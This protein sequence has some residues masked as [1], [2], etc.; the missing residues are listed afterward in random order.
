VVEVIYFLL[1]VIYF[2]GENE[3]CS[4]AINASSPHYDATFRVINAPRFPEKTTALSSPATIR[5]FWFQS[6]INSALLQLTSLCN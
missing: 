4:G 1:E 6:N 3:Q 2:L 5:A